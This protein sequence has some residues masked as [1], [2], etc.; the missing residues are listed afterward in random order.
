[1]IV[2][3]EVRPGR[4]SLCIFLPW[5]PRRQVYLFTSAGGEGGGFA[6][7]RYFSFFGTLEACLFGRRG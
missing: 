5:T 3:E 7:P 1:M 6:P 2:F 4:N